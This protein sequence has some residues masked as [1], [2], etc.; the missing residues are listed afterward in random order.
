[1]DSHQ[2][3]IQVDSEDSEILI[4]HQTVHM[5]L[6]SFSTEVCIQNILS[7]FNSL[8]TSAAELVHIPEMKS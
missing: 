1:M 3:P 5:V 2:S 4:N 8:T 7:L 6:H